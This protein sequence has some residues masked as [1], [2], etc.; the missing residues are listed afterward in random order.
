MKRILL[1]SILSVSAI[2]LTLNS[3]KKT[4]PDTETQSAVDNSVCEGEFTSR[5]SV[6]HGF[7]IKENGV[8]SMLDARSGSCPAIYITPLDTA[9]GFPVTMTLDYGTTGCHR[10][11]LFAG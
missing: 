2:A 9:N 5:M 8:K 10:N 11:C 3:C 7:A 4:E 6:V 1:A